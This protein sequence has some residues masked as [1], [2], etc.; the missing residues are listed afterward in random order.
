MSKQFKYQPADKYI[1]FNKED[2][3]LKTIRVYLP[4]QPDEKL[5][6]GY[7]L[8]P[9]EQRWHAPQLPVK[10]KQ[11]LSK[12]NTLEELNN[13]IYNNQHEYSKEIEWIK[14]EW[15]RRLNGYWFFNNGKA[16]YMDGW[17]YFYCGYW[18]LDIGLPE[19]RYR[20]YL[21]F[22]FA[23]FCYTDTKLPNGVC[24]GRRLCYGFNYPKHRREG[25]TYK[26]QCI[27]YEIISRTRN[28]H[29]GIQSMD[30]PS[31]K[32]VFLDKLVPPWQKMAFFFKPRYTGNS[33]PKTRLYFDQIAV[34]ASAK[35]GVANI[36]IG[37]QS[38]ITYASSA[39]R[40]AYDGD[41]LMFYHDDETGKCLEE[42]V[43]A[44]HMVTKKCLSQANGRIIHGLTIKTSTVGGMIKEGGQNFYKLCKDS[45]WEERNDNGETITGLY[46]LFIPAYVCLDGFIDIYG[47]PV[48]DDPTE[49]D[50][51]R[52]PYPTRDVNGK[53]I[54]AKTYLDNARKAYMK[55]DNHDAQTNFEEEVRMFPTSF[56]ECFISEGGVSGL[57]IHKITKRIKELQFATN[58]SLGIEI[59]NFK[60]LNDRKDGT[61]IFEKT[62]NGRFKVSLL[63]VINNRK[64][65]IS[66][67]D[68]TGMINTYKP[69]GVIKFVSSADPYQFLKTENRRLSMGAG[70]TF[71]LRDE[72]IDPDEKH[73]DLW[74]TYRT[75]CTYVYR[76]E[77]PDDF[78]EDMLMMC[79]YY[80]SMMY[81]EI[82]ID[83]IWK[84]FRRRGYLG[85]LLHGY[86]T[87]G[88][89]RNTPGFYNR[90]AVAQNI[91]SSHKRYLETHCNRIKHIEVLEECKAIK[92]IEDLTNRDLFVAVAGT[93]MA[94]DQILYEPFNRKKQNKYTINDFFNIKS[95]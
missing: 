94:A 13:A 75:V 70:S 88:V 47:N 27:N 11:L 61:V 56:N 36:D 74:E 68:V 93:Y 66:I 84:Y 29:G 41:K 33:D 37:L 8:P 44:R 81:P 26:A 46:N 12:H 20:D 90:G 50:L 49:D 35:G 1:D 21:W 28:A 95:Y 6:D 34:S 85:Y 92:G 87:S 2:D 38:K 77:D 60:W 73:V 79:V 82:N 16:T 53:L 42:N 10:L 83:L 4:K 39:N 31:S 5:I 23:R 25:A 54:G 19:Y 64:E 14:R 51:W 43:Y 69:S 7:G 15:D 40:G 32:A 18:H 55:E 17:H 48:I 59:G 89:K 24:L 91:F 45:M 9:K 22:H 65:K 86:D 30:G 58:S 63:P 67:W 76:P 57:P 80:E 71:M 3:T 52:I 62:S 72:E 78:A